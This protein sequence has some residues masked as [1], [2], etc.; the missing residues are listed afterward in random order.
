MFVAQRAYVR[1]VCSFV[2][3]SIVTHYLG[4]NALED[5]FPQMSMKPNP[6]CDDSFCR[7]RSREVA[8]R[9]AN[10]QVHVQ[11]EQIDEAPLHEDNEWGI[12]LVD[13]SA[14]EAACPQPTSGLRLA[15]DVDKHE[16]TPAAADA[17]TTG[18]EQSLEELMAQMKRL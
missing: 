11:Q 3:G 10:E 2:P 8:Q 12:S 14:P 9:R 4:Y 5:F 16:D 1:I 17:S 18:D 13:E 15:Y 7:Q 6:H